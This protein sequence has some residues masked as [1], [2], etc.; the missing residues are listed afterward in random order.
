MTFKKLSI[1][2]II[3]LIGS[4]LLLSPI[5]TAYGCEPDPFEI[6]TTGSHFIIGEVLT[7]DET[8][9]LI[10]VADYFMP[11]SAT[12]EELVET[13]ET[14]NFPSSSWLL[15]HFNQGD[16]VITSFNGTGCSWDG[17]EEIFHVTSLDYTTLQVED[18]MSK[19]W[20]MAERMM[21][22]FVN[23]RATYNYQQRNSRIYRQHR[24]NPAG[25]MVIYDPPSLILGEITVLNPDEVTI[26][27]WDYVAPDEKEL[28]FDRLTLYR[29]HTTVF[30]NFNIGDDVAVIFRL[31]VGDGDARTL[32]AIPLGSPMDV[33]TI[34]IL[35][36]GDI[37]AE[38]IREDSSI[39]AFY[40]DLI[41]HRRNYPYVVTFG[42]T[43]RYKSV[44][45]LVNGEL[46]MVYEQEEVV[47]EQVES[48]NQ[49]AAEIL[50]SR[51]AT[52]STWLTLTL[53]IVGI[54]GV[55]GVAVMVLVAKTN[56]QV[57][58]DEN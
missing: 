31:P 17:A 3:G 27:I 48:A 2:V 7:I 5:E 26:E 15:E 49:V 34:N 9:I 18:R 42:G 4:V 50:T 43:G 38:H 22:D 41:Q 21:T 51:E 14:I 36:N 33:F 6:F 19:T 13:S 39:S 24:E 29:G 54:G 55:L 40:T 16:Y 32:T 57:L 53:V 12:N 28:A 8:E 25:W 30:N 20:G 23:H 56:K 11:P 44:A 47:I 37:Q 58:N 1:I 46:V 35:E 52:T 10:D 45:R